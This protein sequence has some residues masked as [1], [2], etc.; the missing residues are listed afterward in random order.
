MASTKK[1][2]FQLHKYLGL[3]TGIVVFVVAIT[4][5]CWAFKEEIESL[6]DDSVQVSLQDQPIL[7]PT[8]AKT[9]A[10]EV[11]PNQSI[12]GVL[13]EHGAQPVEVIFYDAEPEF[14]Q[15]VFLN[16]YS[17][18]VIEVKD[19][20][21]GFFA[22]IL[23]GHIR[24]WLPKEIGEQLVSAS[25]LIFLLI[26]IS[27]IVVW[28]PKKRKNLD[29]RLKF[30]WKKNTKWKRKNY[31]LHAITG[32]YICSLAFVLAF[33]GSVISYN[34]LKYVVYKSIGGE[35][36][37]SFIIPDNNSAPLKLVT[38]EKPIDRL[39][40]KL[41]KESP[42]AV[43]YELHYPHDEDES[44]Y[45]ELANSEGL[46]YN[47]DYRFFDQHTLEEI[48]TPGIY[49]KY[50]DAKLSDKVLR[51][52]YDIHIGA[53]GGIAGKILAFIIS[54]LTASLPVTGFLMWYGRNYKKKKK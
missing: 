36:E 52:N 35:K 47:N 32:F 19:H 17:G 27:G 10:K 15:S 54:L 31:D 30:K 5:C 45:V 25:V 7:T 39:I 20:M 12:H 24:M 43:S 26:I 49:G 1:I 14:Y 34:W 40:V 50:K 23:K 3:V 41:M 11:F 29:Q 44:I 51:M 42:N 33:T 37:A 2:F 9:F 13:F 21:S 28:F 46:Y 4:G 8:Q 38:Q 6:L 18:E 22:F 48:E 53:I 16:P